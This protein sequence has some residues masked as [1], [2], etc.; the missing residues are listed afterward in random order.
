MDIMFRI[1]KKL[2]ERIL[3][4]EVDTLMS[5]HAPPFIKPLHIHLCVGYDV[6]AVC[7]CDALVYV[8]KDAS[9]Y[10]YK[11][12]SCRV[13]HVSGSEWKLQPTTIL[14]PAIKEGNLW[15]MTNVKRLDTP[16][17]ISEY[18]PVCGSE[19]T[20]ACFGCDWFNCAF[21][22]CE[23]PCLDR[24]PKHWAKVLFVGH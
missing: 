6:V 4:G 10:Y 23:Q 1:S 24:A 11:D 5:H 20:D 21:M 14:Q 17:D 7:D 16:R 9:G 19:H 13:V 22:V 12:P 3:N 15:H 18:V 2:C 8:S